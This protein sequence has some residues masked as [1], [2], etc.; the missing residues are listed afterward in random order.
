MRTT[1][2]ETVSEN[3]VTINKNSKT[4][5]VTIGT[6]ISEETTITL[7]VLMGAKEASSLGMQDLQLFFETVE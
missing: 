2:G 6:E 3:D 5:A 4:E 7:K 1:V